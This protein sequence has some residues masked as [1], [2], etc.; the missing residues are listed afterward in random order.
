MLTRRVRLLGTR[1][2]WLSGVILL[3]TGTVV[4]AAVPVAPPV[5][6]PEMPVTAVNLAFEQAQNSPGVAVDPTD[7]RYVALASRVDGPEFDCALHVSGDRGRTW[8]PAKPVPQLP[9]G[10]ERCY[11]P[12]IAFDRQ[13]VLYYLFV[14]LHGKGNTPMG[15]FLTTSADRREFSPPRRV[16]GPDR[17]MVRMV[18]D[19]TAGRGGRIHLVW[20][21]PKSPPVL[22]GFATAGNPI[23]ASHS[24]D[25]GRTLS[26]PVRV[27]DPVR[28]LVVA[29]AVALGRDHRLHVAYYDLEKD[30]RDYQGLEGPVWDGTWSLIVSTSVDGGRSFTRHVAA[31]SGLVPPARVM[32]IFT[33]PPPALAADDS[34]GLWVSW[35]DARN[36]DWDVFLATSGDD[37]RSF[38]SAMRLNDDPVANGRHQYLPR[39]AVAPSGRLDAILYDRRDDAQ[40][41]RNHVYYTFSTDGGR[42]FRPNLRVTSESFHAGTGARYSVP[43]AAGLVEF[44]SRLALAP[45]RSGVLA[46][47]TDTRNVRFGNTHQDIFAAE[48]TFG[49]SAPSGAGAPLWAIVAGGVGVAAIAGLGTRRWCAGRSRATPVDA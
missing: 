21:E 18:L 48:I 45:T 43:S 42:S 2:G 13:G 28:S 11:A 27:S 8:R 49:G 20:L 3:T 12:E 47:W 46:A 26:V 17:F 5:V 14:G 22:G 19:P 31:A 36:G 25:G 38:A 24:D 34:G 4:E 41:E 35:W 10:A 29:P 44:G 1:L 33:M 7:S 23:L 6:R 40:N 16:L 39:L 30:L 37:G 9:P 32:L 15:V